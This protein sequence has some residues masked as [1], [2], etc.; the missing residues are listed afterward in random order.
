MDKKEKIAMVTGA[1][2]GIGFETVRQLAQQD[3]EVILTSR[4]E[5]MGKKAVQTLQKE[6]LTAHCLPLVVD[7]PGSIE[8]LKDNVL[9]QFGRLDILINN[10][11]I[12]LDEGKSI[13]TISHKT[14]EDTL[15]TNLFGPFYLSQAFLPVMEKNGYG[16][17]VNVSSGYGASNTLDHPNTASYK[18]SKYALNALTRLLASSVDSKHVKVNVADPGWVKTDMGGPSAPRTPAEAAEGIVWL[19]TLPGDGPSGMFFYDK[20]ITGW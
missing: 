6:G 17:V 7:D 14:F 15:H 1:N 3:I 11:G 12:Y 5:E 10:A 16:R 2:R 4:N 8:R 9:T 19:A 13:L 20:K 18:L